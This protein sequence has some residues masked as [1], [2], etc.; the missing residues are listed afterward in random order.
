MWQAD[1][2]NATL[3]AHVAIPEE[4]ADW[5]RG[6]QGMPRGPAAGSR[7]LLASMTVN[8]LS[9]ALP[10]VI[11]QVYDRIL[12]NQATDTLL[13][14][15]A[16][17]CGVLLLEAVLRLARSY[18]SGWDAARF[19]HLTAC[20][21]VD[22]L[23]AGNIGQFERDA[24]GVHLDRLSA[25]DMLRDYHAGQGKLLIVDLPFILLFLGLI[26]AIAGWL[27]L[28]PLSLLLL[29]AGSALLVGSMLKSALQE[30][31]ALDDRRYNFIIE[32]LSG[33][34]TVKGLAMEALLQRRYE[35][36]QESGA[37]STYS[38][39][40][41]SNLAQGV[42][43][44][45][46]N[47]TMV[48]V[49][50]VGSTLVI[51]GELSIGGLAACTL[52]AGR[53]VQPL[54]RALGIWTQF[55]NIAVAQER[56]DRLFAAAPEGAAD[57]PAMPPL[58][59]GIELRDLTFAYGDDDAP[60]V[61]GIDLSIAPGEV[62]GITGG[63][64]SGKSTLLLLML[65]ALKPSRGQVFFDGVDI[66]TRDAYS[67]RRQVAFLPQSAALF[68]GTILDNLTM[69]RGVDAVE[70]G[71]AASQLLGLDR[72]IRRLPAG[73]ETRVGD[74]AQDELPTGI[75]QGIVMARALAQQP[76]VILFDEANSALDGKSDATLKQALAEMK[77]GPSMVLVSHRPSLLALADRTYHLEAGRLE[78]RRAGPEPQAAEA[79]AEPSELAPSGAPAG[80]G[81]A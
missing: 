65:G 33:I 70:H 46:S 1:S 58:E 29:L 25:T 79:V 80:A 21:A 23:L 32:V 38:C 13:L 52:L 59:G 76:R 55:Q 71:L 41:F 27:A 31:A 24:P 6:S 68:Q 51:A 22:R 77:G 73:Y 10:L 54:L 11:L 44:I 42:G 69:F 62:I 45:F 12:P 20:R 57:L 49:A 14:L 81:A 30:R 72:Q 48:A 17:L 61:E 2:L 18:V 43:A 16:G 75:K 28:V 4:E 66:A 63:T 53:S 3:G 7:V 56:L 60:V 36:L 39:T 37:A 78:L 5:S 35:R 47:L 64:G 74:G 8:L 19:E 26:W 67:L 50:A 15:I 9:L 40:Y 34:Q